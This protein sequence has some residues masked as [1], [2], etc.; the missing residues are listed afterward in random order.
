MKMNVWAEQLH[1]QRDNR[2]A[3]DEID[4]RLLFQQPRPLIE[5]IV[6]RPV[7]DR[8][9]MEKG[10]RDPVAGREQSPHHFLI[11]RLF[12]HEEA[13]LLKR[14]AL[15][16]GELNEFHGFLFSPKS[17]RLGFDDDCSGDHMTPST[18]LQYFLEHLPID[19]LG[20]RVQS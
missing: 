12:H 8:R 10:M 17:T 15:L 16:R 18:A 13:I 5:V 19:M 3:G 6:F 14:S 20:E 4:H 1:D 7:K 2:R 11:E 9:L